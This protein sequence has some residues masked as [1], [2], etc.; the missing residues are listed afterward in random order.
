MEFKTGHATS[1]KTV[2]SRDEHIGQV[3]LYALMMDTL[4]LIGP[5]GILHYIRYSYVFS[6]YQCSS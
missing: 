6:V 4:K 1:G 3:F 2:V 5:N